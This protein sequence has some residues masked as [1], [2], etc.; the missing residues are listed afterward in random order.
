MEQHRPKLRRR[1]WV[2]AATM[3]VV[4]YVASSGPLQ[5][6]HSLTATFGDDGVARWSAG[7]IAD[8]IT[9]DQPLSREELRGVQV[10]FNGIQR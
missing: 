7:S 1:R 4:L 3:L 2:V 8:G 10:D 9:L 6:S 5:F